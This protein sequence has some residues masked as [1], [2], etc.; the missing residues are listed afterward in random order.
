MNDS[1]LNSQCLSNSKC[2]FSETLSPKHHGQ[3]SFDK[4]GY[5]D[6]VLASFTTTPHAITTANNAREQ[7]YPSSSISRKGFTATLHSSF[8][9]TYQTICDVGI[10][11]LE[12]KAKDYCSLW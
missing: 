5:Q 10:K 1:D 12:L 3:V 7:I 2:Y 11:R 8:G 9:V 6:S 4:K